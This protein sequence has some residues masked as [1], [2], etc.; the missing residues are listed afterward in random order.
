MA[1]QLDLKVIGVASLTPRV[2]G[3]ELESSDR[4]LLPKYTAGAHLDLEVP[5][6]G[7]RSYSLISD[8]DHMSTYRIAVLL[9]VAG[10][11]GSAAMHQLAVGDV[12]RANPPRNDFEID[13]TGTSFLLIG[14]GIGITPLLSMT[15]RLERL[16][17]PYELLYC[18]RS[19]VE[20]A[21][22][23]EVDG[24][25]AG[26]ARLIHD[27]GDP[28]AGLDLISTLAV[29]QPGQHLYVCGPRG[30]ID[31]ARGAAHAW[32]KDHVH[33]EL[34]ASGLATPDHGADSGNQ[35]FE[36]VL[37]KTG[38]TLQVG[39]DQTILEVLNDY[40]IPIPSVCRDGF[41]GSCKTRHLSGGVDHRDDTLDDEE[42]AEFMQVCV[43]RALPGETLV[44][45]V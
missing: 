37:A 42:R 20:T 15:H 8:P 40:G 41:C 6:V 33:Y 13:E 36:V 14:G 2:R 24:R 16:G 3:I 29:P 32:P 5:G 39:A 43:S 9:E 45:D 25:L 44:L 28:A 10:R 17:K 38:G 26:K 22:L 35:P 21:F 27:G 12:L 1:Q 23:D 7:V 34:F 19:R 18:T 31:A 4:A 11:G 30:L